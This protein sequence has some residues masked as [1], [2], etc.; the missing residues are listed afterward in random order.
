MQLP[1]YSSPS[2]P[3]PIAGI[4]GLAT[5]LLLLPLLGSPDP[6]RAQSTHPDHLVDR[7]LVWAV[8]SEGSISVDGS[9][10]EAAWEQASVV[11]SLVQTDPEEGNPASQDTEIRILF[12]EEA[13][14]VGAQ[15]LDRG[16]VTRRLGRRDMPRGDSDWF[17][18][19]LDSYHDHTTAFLF[20]VNPSGVKRDAVR[21]NSSDGRDTDD[22]SWDAVWEVATLIHDDGW[23]VEMRIPF[24]QLRFASREEQIWGIQFERVIGRLRESAVLAF[25]PR[26]EVGGV[27]TYGHLLGLTGIVTGSRMELTPYALARGEHIDP[28]VNPY[29]RPVE[30]SVSGGADLLYRVTSDFTVNATVNPDFGQVEVDPAVVN[31]GVYETSFEERRPFFVEGSEIFSFGRGTPASQV[32]YPR[33]IGGAPRLAPPSPFADVPGETRI[34]AAGKLSGRTANGWSVGLLDAI[35]AEENARFRDP[36]GRD[37][38]MV[39]EPR[40]NY[41]IARARRDLR[42]GQTGVGAILSTVNRS[43]P[44]EYLRTHVPSGAYALGF[45]LI[46]E[47]LDRNWLLRGTL[48]GSRVEGTPQSLI[49]VQERGN[50][51]FQ[52]PDALHLR[53]DSTSITLDGYLA[54]VALEK[55]GGLHWLGQ[56]AGTITSPDY[57]VNDLGLVRRTDRRDLEGGL[58][59]QETRPGMVL[60]RWAVRGRA[61]H[62]WNHGGDR[63]MAFGVLSGEA[64]SLGYW[65]VNLESEGRL[66]AL[67]DRNTRGG[68]IMIRPAYSRIRMGAESDPRRGLLLGLGFMTKSDEFGGR[69][70][71]AE[72]SLGLQTSPSWN[73]TLAPKAFRSRYPAQYVATIPQPDYLDTFGRRYLFARFVQTEVGLEMR[74]NYT[75]SPVMTLELFAQP[76]LSSGD[77]GEVSALAAPRS[78]DFVPFEGDA[79]D[80][81]FNLRSLRGNAVLRWEWRAGSTLFLVWQQVRSEFH[82]TTEFDFQRDSTA[83]FAAPADHVF[84][85]KASYWLTP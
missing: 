58:V 16:P 26:S 10:S 66:R 47:F 6:V 5:S 22:E 59:Y 79:P 7:P 83:L 74:L 61:R 63:I 3:L 55:R 34:L 29:R 77:Y 71:E 36:D 42:G 40:T 18:V 75:F 45:D 78:Y 48:V 81:S 85:V 27:Q 72:I 13:L 4:P 73:L 15:L 19:A 62:E 57:E 17:G 2:I 46:H 20:E 37:Q 33:R 21:S 44:T 30:Y 70:R 65:S 50:H 64:T 51:F 11:G 60:R 43:L 12:S 56:I 35:T 28:G 32:F 23:S 82:P 38:S 49:R 52:R 9:L 14:Y 41:A 76:L 53:V 69:E 67:D 68:P 39:V 8:R 31:L 54:S 24:S 84:V 1:F 80:R 25:T